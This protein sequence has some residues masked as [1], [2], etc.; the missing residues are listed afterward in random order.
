MS[1]SASQSSVAAVSSALSPFWFS[2]NN[3]LNGCIDFIQ[4]L[5]KSKASLNTGQKVSGYDQENTIVKCKET[6]HPKNQLYFYL[7]KIIA[8][9]ERT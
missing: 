4:I 9:L 8:K 5:Q 1:P 2:I 7:V 3:F 6:R